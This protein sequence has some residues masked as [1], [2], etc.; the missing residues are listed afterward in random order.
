MAPLD[1]YYTSFLDMEDTAAG[2]SAEV[3]AAAAV[4][5]H[6]A[7]TPPDTVGYHPALPELRM[8]V[9]LNSHT[10]HNWG[11]S[12]VELSRLQNFH[13]YLSAAVVARSALT[14]GKTFVALCSR[15]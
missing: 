7:S 1:Q 3:A 15:L 5:Q 14:A 13:L 2:I 11:D 9:V 8:V 10:H 4:D 6:L 12:V